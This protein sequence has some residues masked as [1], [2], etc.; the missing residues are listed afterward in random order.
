MR[1]S[2]FMTPDPVTID[3]GTSVEAALRLMDDV[4]IRH[5]PV[6]E[7][8]E[9]VGVV[10]NR[11]LLGALNVA[12]TGEGPTPVGRVMK[13]DPVT[14]AP[15]DE[16]IAAAVECSVNGIGCLPVVNGGRLDGIVSE[17]D[18]LRLL[19]SPAASEAARAMP[20][21]KLASSGLVTVP[22]DGTYA[23]VDTVMNTKGVRHV[24]VVDTGGQLLGMV[25]DRDMRRALGKGLGEGAQVTEFMSSGVVTLDAGATVA[26]AAA[27]MAD[28]RMGAIVVTEGTDA[29]GVGVVTITDMLE[30][31]L[32]AL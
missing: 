7:G 1:V 21:A 30:A 12:E 27:V 20:L 6:L 9:L 18:F 17:M 13:S 22:D 26:E 23:L 11:D 3:P 10:S 24:P 2:E 8:S 28:R 32:G 15:D 31:A 16:I 29:R 19:A 14:V 5:L 25:S 4:G